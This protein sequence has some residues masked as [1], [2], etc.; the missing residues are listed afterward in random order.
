[1]NSSKSKIWLLLTIIVAIITTLIVM[2]YMTRLRESMKPPQMS[3]V[4]VAAKKIPK[5][6]LVTSEMV[7][8][9]EMPTKYV[10]SMALT[11]F[12][13]KL[14]QFSKAE[15]EPEAVI[16]SSQLASEKNSDELQFIIPEGK[17][18]IA[19]AT[20]PPSAV[21]GQIKSGD[22]VDVLGIYTRPPKEE[23][24]ATDFD[25]TKVITLLQKVLVLS[26]G[27]GAQAK[28]DANQPSETITLALSPEDAEKITLMET[29]GKVKF[30][31]RPAADTNT[32]SINGVSGQTL[33]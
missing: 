30:D 28:K 16:L 21:A 32:P 13:P 8:T 29:L 22:F 24:K 6:T 7:K 26:L 10:H 20:N 11:S 18:A 14:K 25:N 19:I 33:N 12:D 4:V 27:N 9:V 1:L 3:K 17:R 15:L 2:N 23:S 31:L 5:D